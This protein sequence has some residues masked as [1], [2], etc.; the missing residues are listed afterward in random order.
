MMRCGIACNRDISP[1]LGL[2]CSRPVFGHGKRRFVQALLRSPAGRGAPYERPKRLNFAAI[3]GKTTS[4]PS[5]AA[6]TKLLL[7]GPILPTLLCL[8]APNILTLLAFAGVITF[9]GFFL[10]A[11]V[12]TPSLAPHWHFRG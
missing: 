7:E 10:G 8:A 3:I 11:S 12:P 4:S 5:A 9:D 2:C 1:I 6:R